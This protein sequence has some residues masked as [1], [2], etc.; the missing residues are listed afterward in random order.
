MYTYFIKVY[1]IQV[2]VFPIIL[3]TNFENK[4]S[5]KKKNFVTLKSSEKNLFLSYVEITTENVNY[6]CYYL[7]IV[8]TNIIYFIT[9]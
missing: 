6:F 1:N 3:S 5:I 9:R 2:R 4:I 7:C 8:P